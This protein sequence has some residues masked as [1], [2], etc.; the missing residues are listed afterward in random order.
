MVTLIVGEGEP[1][2]EPPHLAD[3]LSEDGRLEMLANRQRLPKLAAEPAKE[4]NRSG[5]GRHQRILARSPGTR[6]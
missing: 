3:V 1:A 2:D 5:T 4:V 6:D